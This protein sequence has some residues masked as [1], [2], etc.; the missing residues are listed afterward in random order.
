MTDILSIELK[1]RNAGMGGILGTLVKGSEHSGG[2]YGLG[3][4]YVWN[5]Y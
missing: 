3:T 2:K 4:L 5:Y 1:L